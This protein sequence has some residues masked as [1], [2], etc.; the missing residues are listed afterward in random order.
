[1]IDIKDLSEEQVNVLKN[2]TE[3]S[4]IWGGCV[5]HLSKDLTGY[6][7]SVW[8]QEQKVQSDIDTATGASLRNLAALMGIY[9]MD[10]NTDKEVRDKIY[11]IK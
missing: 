1:M 8:S 4:V 5:I 6:D 2:I 7:L 10:Y 9:D 3:G 11:S